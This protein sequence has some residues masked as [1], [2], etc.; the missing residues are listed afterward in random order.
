MYIPY[1]CTSWI[2]KITRN[3]FT[4]VQNPRTTTT[5]TRTVKHNKA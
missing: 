2:I 5:D 3:E 4:G 1:T